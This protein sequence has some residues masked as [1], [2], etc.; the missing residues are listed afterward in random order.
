MSKNFICDYES[1]CGGDG[2]GGSSMG[3]G[4]LIRHNDIFLISVET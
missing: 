4:K 3:G 1:L 2:G